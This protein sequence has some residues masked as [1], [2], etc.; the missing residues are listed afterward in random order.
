MEKVEK[1]IEV[2]V[3]VHVAYKQWT[4]VHDTSTTNA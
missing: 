2:D 1:T 4:Q 3:P